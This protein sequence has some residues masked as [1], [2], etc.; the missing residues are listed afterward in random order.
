MEGYYKVF[1]A[2]KIGQ[3]SFWEFKTNQMHLQWPLWKNN[4]QR[5][6]TAVGNGQLYSLI[7]VFKYIGLA[8]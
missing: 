4:G 5:K 8:W 2:F 1:Q 6:I 7:Y 3:F